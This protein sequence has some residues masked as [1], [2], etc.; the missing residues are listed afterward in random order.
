MY[1]VLKNISLGSPLEGIPWVMSVESEF[2]R[3]LLMT[4]KYNV[5]Y[6][7][8]F[9]QCNSVEKII[10]DILAI[11]KQTQQTLLV[12]EIGDLVFS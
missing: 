4:G 3:F 6:I 7:G 11:K 1:A 8:T 9:E 12:N 2:Y 5:E 10:R